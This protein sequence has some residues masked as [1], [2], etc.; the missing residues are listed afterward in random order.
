MASSGL[1][2]WS[3]ETTRYLGAR[4]NVQIRDVKHSVSVKLLPIEPHAPQT[5]EKLR[6][7]VAEAWKLGWENPQGSLTGWKTKPYWGEFIL[8][9]G[10]GGGGG[11]GNGLHISVALGQ[12]C[13]FVIYLNAASST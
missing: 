10:W 6:Y 12:Y 2:A 9:G 1:T 5:F 4:E 7:T 11:S 13:I 3:F 8:G